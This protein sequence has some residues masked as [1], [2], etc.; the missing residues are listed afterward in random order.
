MAKPQKARRD[1]GVDVSARWLDA[2][3]AAADELPN[4]QQFPNTPA[5]Q[6]QLVRWA[7]QG[8]RAARVA[9]EAT[10]LYSLDLA[11][12]LHATAAGTGREAAAM[13][14]G[15]EQGWSETL[16]RLRER[17]RAIT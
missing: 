16:D 11:L 12:T 6:R 5:G 1:V 4:V 9:L 3:R 15:M 17:S 14:R 10:G 13:L 7:T 8:G 2:S